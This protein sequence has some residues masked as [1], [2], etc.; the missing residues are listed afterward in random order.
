MFEPTD[1]RYFSSPPVDARSYSPR[2]FR[3][4]PR[5]S[6]NKTHNNDKKAR[7]PNTDKRAI[8]QLGKLFEPEELPWSEA[9]VG[10]ELEVIVDSG[11]KSKQYNFSK[12]KIHQL[13]ADDANDAKD[14]EDKE[15]KEADTEEAEAAED[16][17]A[18]IDVGKLVSVKQMRPTQLWLQLYIRVA[19]KVAW[20]GPFMESVPFGT[21]TK[22]KVCV[23]F[24]PG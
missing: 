14:A 20:G 22:K 24:S 18:R 1:P 2:S 21:K 19:V 11:R 8:A 6:R 16:I 4:K 15:A 5:K 10:D 23:W 9:E 7:N 13:E 3:F 17:E 12:R